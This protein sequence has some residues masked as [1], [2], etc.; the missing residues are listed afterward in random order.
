MFL[1]F[2]SRTAIAGAIIVVSISILVVMVYILTSRIL[3]IFDK[4]AIFFDIY[5]HYLRFSSYRG[6]KTSL[7][8]W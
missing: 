4:T 7:R 2:S 3:A 6:Q 1:I 5:S 8:V